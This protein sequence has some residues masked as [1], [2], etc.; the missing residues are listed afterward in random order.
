M[1]TVGSRSHRHS[2]PSMASR[3]TRL[4]ILEPAT[5]EIGVRRFRWGM[6]ALPLLVAGLVFGVREVS[7]VEKVLAAEGVRAQRVL[8]YELQPGGSIDVPIEPGTD[9]FR[10]AV[11]A[12]RRGKLSAQPHVVHLEVAASG[13]AGARID[14]LAFEVPGTTTRVNPEDEGI[15]IGDP[16]AVNVDVHGVGTGRL[17]I[18]LEGIEGADAALVRV[19]RRDE[20]FAKQLERRDD[21]LGT[22]ERLHL[23]RRVGELDW[24][25][26]DEDEQTAFLSARWRKVAALSDGKSLITRA[27]ALAPKPTRAQPDVETPALVSA[28]LRGDEKIAFVAHGPTTLEIRADGDSES[29]LSALVRRTDGTSET[30][31]NKGDLSIDVPDGATLGFEIGRDTPGI[32]SVRAS[33]PTKIEPSTHAVAWRATPQ[34]PV[35][36]KAGTRSI[37]LRVTARRPLPRTSVEPVTIALDTT[38]APVDGTP[39]TDMLRAE[40]ARSSFE[41]YDARNPIEAPTTSAVF[42]LLVPAGATATLVPEDGPIDLSLAELDPEA[43]PRPVA[44]WEAHG[45]PPPVDEIGEV[46]WGGFLPRRPTNW[47]AFAPSTRTTIRI[48]HRFVDHPTPAT[49]AP[50]YRTKRPEAV[51]VRV[52][53]GMTFDPID[54]SF[55]IEVPGGEPL[56]LPVRLF[57]EE[58]MDLV[59][60][61]D[62]ESIDRLALGA[63]QRITT[64]RLVTVDGQYKSIVVLGDDLPA[65]THVLSFEAPD[66][67]RAWV[68][69]PWVPKPRP[70]KAPPPDP[71]WIEGDL[72]E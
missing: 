49:K 17:S 22:L 66:G 64:P 40:R 7:R 37:V 5:R 18:A 28:D 31:T 24:D 38:I 10:I 29:M 72:E 2:R 56:V 8:V 45:P 63:V 51:D 25:V 47:S 58:K 55:D 42:H 19:Y 6:L 30:T 32:V 36:V 68:H 39:H 71:H 20:L 46:A 13:A 12:M 67:K 59:A 44:A 21:K 34:L 52:I 14:D 50:K 4:S 26:L 35:I 70:P 9:V 16:E 43:A 53:D 33:D 62:G 48:P 57:T 23:A 54:V 11:H 69:L 1:S 41:R 61:I 65:G 15:A 27:I 60:K 3:L